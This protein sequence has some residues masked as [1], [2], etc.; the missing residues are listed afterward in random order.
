MAFLVQSVDTERPGGRRQLGEAEH[1]RLP[2]GQVAERLSDRRRGV[3]GEVADP[4]PVGV[5]QP[6]QP[7]IG[8][9]VQRV[10]RL[11]G[12]PRRRIVWEDPVDEHYA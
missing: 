6:A 1:G 3:E 7:L 2:D 9:H 8:M 5:V 12:S 11:V 10:A 4:V